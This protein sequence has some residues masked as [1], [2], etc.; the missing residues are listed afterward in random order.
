MRSLFES[1]LFGRLVLRNRV[2]MARL[3]RNRANADG[4][5]S[6]LGTQY[7]KQRASRSVPRG[8]FL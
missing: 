6:E 7:Y 4:V 3:T 8:A 5:P 1:V 2:F